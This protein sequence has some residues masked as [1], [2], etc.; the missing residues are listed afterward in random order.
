MVPRQPLPWTPTHSARYPVA[1]CDLL[2][3]AVLITALIRTVYCVAGTALSASPALVRLTLIPAL[4]GSHWCAPH[5][6]DGDAEAEKNGYLP[7]V[8]C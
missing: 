1:G 8:V 3:V 6:T 2:V 7:R 5:V 4:E